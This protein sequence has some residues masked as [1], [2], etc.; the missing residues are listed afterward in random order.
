MLREFLIPKPFVDSKIQTNGGVTLSIE[1]HQVNKG[2]QQLLLVT[3]M[4]IA[5]CVWL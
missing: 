2:N 1:I 4:L 3:A 5:F